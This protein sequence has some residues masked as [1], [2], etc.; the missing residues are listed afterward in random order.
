MMASVP[1][2]LLE[3]IYQSQVIIYRVYMKCM[4]MEEYT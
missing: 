3:D 2:A 4:K 1:V